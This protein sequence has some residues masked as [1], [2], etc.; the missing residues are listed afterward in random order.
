MSLLSVVLLVLAALA[1]LG[2]EWPRLA[3]A[4][5]LERA[6]RPRRQ[7]STARPRRPARQGRQG[8]PARPG[9]AKA[10]TAARPAGKGHL[11][12]VEDTDDADD[13]VA[14]VRRDLDRLPTIDR[15]KDA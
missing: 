15:D 9:S 6:A 11:R 4:L 13:F 1:V 5:G 12:V 14:S 3:Q 10:D 8:R 7:G 2:A